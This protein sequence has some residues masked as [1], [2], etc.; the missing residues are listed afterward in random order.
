MSRDI[1][2]ANAAELSVCELPSASRLEEGAQSPDILAAQHIFERKH[3]CPVLRRLHRSN[4]V[5]MSLMVTLLGAVASAAFLRFG[6][7]S[8]SKTVRED[9][10]RAAVMM[11]YQMEV[12]WKSYEVSAL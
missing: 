5:A 7:S 2:K 8:A 10:D 6:I 4:P 11:L 12:A 1:M 3:C 9:F